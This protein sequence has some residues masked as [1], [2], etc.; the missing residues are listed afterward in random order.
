MYKFSCTQ[1]WE[2]EL[3]WRK[4]RSPEDTA[5]LLS[6]LSTGLQTKNPAPFLTTSPSPWELGSTVRFGGSQAKQYCYSFFKNFL[7][8]WDQWNSCA[9]PWY[10][11]NKSHW[12]FVLQLSSYQQRNLVTLFCIST[13]MRLVQTETVTFFLNITQYTYLWETVGVHI[14]QKYFRYTKRLCPLKKY[15][16]LQVEDCRCEAPRA[17]FLQALQL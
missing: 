4:S 12:D 17:S 5:A 14:T 9:F 8:I 15:M 6:S 2:A 13:N 11:F 10:S 3:L 7:A 1:G 16:Q